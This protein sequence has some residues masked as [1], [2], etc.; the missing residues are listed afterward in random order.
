L[1]G[2]PQRHNL[3]SGDYRQLGTE[4]QSA[5]SHPNSK[6]PEFVLVN[7]ENN[8]FSVQKLSSGQWQVEKLCKLSL[9]ETFR[10]DEMTII[11]MPTQ[12]TINAFRIQGRERILTTLTISN[13]ESTRRVSKFPRDI[14]AEL[15]I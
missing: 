7:S 1:E 11:A 15:A 13:D 12:N 10:Q 2:N 3:D 8:I 4:I 6:R 5:T 14:A 9:N